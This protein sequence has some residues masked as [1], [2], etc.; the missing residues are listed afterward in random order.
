[1]EPNKP[2][3]IIQPLTL[4]ALSTV[5]QYQVKLAQKVKDLSVGSFYPQ[6]NVWSGISDQQQAI[7]K[8]H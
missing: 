3:P 1:M 2:T 7:A 5:H 4:H 6:G 8:Q